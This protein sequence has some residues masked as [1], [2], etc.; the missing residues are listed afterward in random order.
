MIETLPAER[1]R[2]YSTPGPITSE[3]LD[4]IGRVVKAIG[5]TEFVPKDLRGRP[6]AC[7]AAILYGR[8]LGLDGMVALR[9][10]SVVDGKPSL[11]ATA[12]L[13]RVRAAGHSITIE[14]DGLGCTAHGRRFDNGDEF[15]V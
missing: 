13:G 10:V 7:L 1:S 4:V 15:S 2:I 5:D 9:E 6:G 12:I 11:S 8:A 14:G 3:E